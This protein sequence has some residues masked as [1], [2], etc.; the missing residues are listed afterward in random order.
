MR[1]LPAALILMNCIL[2]LQTISAST[3]NAP[4]DPYLW[5]EDVTG[6]KAL[7][8][9]RQQNAVSTKELEASG[10]FQPLRQRLL[11]ILDS[12]ERIPVASKHGQFLYNFW[13]DEKNV[14]GLWRRTTLEE[15]KKDKPRW[16]TVLDLDQLAAREKENWVWKG[17]LVIEPDDDLA[18]VRLSRGGADAS[19][20]REFDLKSINFVQDGFVLPEA[21]SRV[22]WRNRNALYVATDFGPVH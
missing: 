1:Y 12:K 17:A 14:R 20:T 13:R 19:V 4:E 2:G 6:E 9:V 11:S 21:K 5:L 7:N 16:E 8:W 15:Y 18:L 22:A 10:D 3:N